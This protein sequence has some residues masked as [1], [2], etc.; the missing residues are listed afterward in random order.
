MM[1]SRSSLSARATLAALVIAAAGCAR[2]P[3]PQ[4]TSGPS[5]GESLYRAHCVGCHGGAGA[6]DGPM[7]DHLKVL[8]PDLREI[9]R[10]NDGHYPFEQIRRV[11]D[12]RQPVAGHGGPDMPV[13]G[14]IFL[15]P[16]EGYDE[17]SVRQ[18]VVELARYLGSIQTVP[19]P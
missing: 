2:R 13:W 17:T 9:S 11:I 7:V 12:G 19:S 10:R 6:G 5:T 15:T 18:K 3:L 1:Q 8:P 4:V 16:H 14:D